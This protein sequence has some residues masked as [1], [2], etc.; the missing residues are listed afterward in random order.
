MIP[1]YTNAKSITT[2]GDII[3]S[4]GNTVF[5]GSEQIILGG[6]FEVLNGASFEAVVIPCE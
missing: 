4:T 1:T 6:G 3:L 2:I 5:E